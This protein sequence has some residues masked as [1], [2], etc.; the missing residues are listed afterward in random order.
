MKESLSESPKQSCTKEAP[1]YLRRHA[2]HKSK[3]SDT[4]PHIMII[5]TF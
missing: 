5:V 3:L 1:N 2:W 4:D